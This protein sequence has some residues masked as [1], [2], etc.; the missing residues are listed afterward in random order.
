MSKKGRD[1]EKE[2]TTLT[3]GGGGNWASTGKGQSEYSVAKPVAMPKVI[4]K[5]AEEGK[6]TLLE[7][8]V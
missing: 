8:A 5:N 4:L 1:E 6:R 3:A 2:S 7:V